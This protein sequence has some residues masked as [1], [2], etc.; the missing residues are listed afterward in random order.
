MG[1]WGTDRR[2]ELTLIIASRLSCF[3]TTSYFLHGLSY[4]F[5]AFFLTASSEQHVENTEEIQSQRAKTPNAPPTPPLRTVPRF[6]HISFRPPAP[7]PPVPLHLLPS[8]HAILDPFTAAQHRV[9]MMV[10]LPTMQ[11]GPS[12]PPCHPPPDHASWT[13][14]VRSEM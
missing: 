13:T 9:V 3:S 4:L 6:R 2:P 5:F 8:P 14:V 12:R 1:G 11:Y 7:P 10:H